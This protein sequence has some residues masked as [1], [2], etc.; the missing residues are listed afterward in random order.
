MAE[1][2][3]NTIVKKHHDIRITGINRDK[4]RKTN[5]SDTVYQVYLELSESPPQAWRSIF[6]GEWKIL[7]P[8]QPHLWQAA[9]VDRAFLLMHCPLKEITLQL[10]ALKKAVSLTNTSYKQYL[11][12]QER[13][14]ERREDVWQQERDAVD[15]IADSLHFD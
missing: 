8:D 15:D 10:P 12:E 14:Q 9:S 6:D 11:Q 7:N 5:G 2:D 3:E 1:T 4:T 13:E